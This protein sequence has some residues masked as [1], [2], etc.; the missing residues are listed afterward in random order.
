MKA[1][2][3]KIATAKLRRG[4]GGEEYGSVVA[5]QLHGDGPLRSHR[6]FWFSVP[7]GMLRSQGIAPNVEVDVTF[8]DSEESRDRCITFLRGAEVVDVHHGGHR[9]NV[10]APPPPEPKAREDLGASFG[11]L[12]FLFEVAATKLKY[13]KVSLQDALGGLVVLSR[14]G[15][16][17]Q[18]PGT[19]NVTD[20]KP[21]GTNT[22]YGRIELDGKFEPGR[23][24]APEVV[25]V[26][27]EFA[28][29]PAGTAAR[30]GRLTGHCAFCR[31]ELSDE[32]SLAV[33]YGG[34]CAGHYGLPWGAAAAREAKAADPSMAEAIA[35]PKEDR[36]EGAIDRL[37]GW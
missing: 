2:T 33:G 7:A 28:A 22:W 27:R 32:R 26:L 15:A 13:P 14:A 30:Y 4:R 31:R 24:C 21:Y 6:K 34:T 35:P 20:G 8:R 10:P 16:L 3:L 5:R 36:A 9:V 11:E 37:A 18:R 19:V 23:D 29:D 25:E 12:V 1:L 17:A